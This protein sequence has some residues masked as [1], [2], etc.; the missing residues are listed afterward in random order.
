MFFAVYLSVLAV[1]FSCDSKTEVAAPAEEKFRVDLSTW[2]PEV[3]KLPPGFAPKMPKGR[4]TLLFAPGWRKPDAEDFWSYVFLME[5]EESD[6]DS[7]RLKEIFELYFDGLI[8]AVGQGKAFDLPADPADVLI[9]RNDGAHYSGLVKTYDAFGSGD[10][11]RL[12]VVVDTELSGATA[13]ILRVQISPQE[14]GK[15]EIWRS[16]KFAIDSL[17]FE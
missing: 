12:H 10:E 7:K 13:T 14:P 11:L 4:E 1:L 6:L 8:G 5:I 2:T 17:H 3:I 15:I 9:R 16:L